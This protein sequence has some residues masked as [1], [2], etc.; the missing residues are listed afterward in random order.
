[1]K[2]EYPVLRL[3][4]LLPEAQQTAMVFGTNSDVRKA[5]VQEALDV[6]SLIGTNNKLVDDQS[7]LGRQVQEGVRLERLGG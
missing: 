1:M 3:C 5:V 6:D 2:E 4:L 7:D